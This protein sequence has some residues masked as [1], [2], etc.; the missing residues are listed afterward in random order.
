MAHPPSLDTPSSASPAEPAPAPTTIT[1]PTAHP[2]I[3]RTASKTG[4]SPLRFSTTPSN[5]HPQ[6]AAT[7]QPSKRSFDQASAASPPRS[8]PQL[9]PPDVDQT[10]PPY[11][12][13]SSMTS[14][15]ME[16][17][18][19]PPPEEITTARA[20]PAGGSSTQLTPPSR[21]GHPPNKLAGLPRPYI[22]KPIIPSPA[23]MQETAAAIPAPP[24]A[25]RPRTVGAKAAAATR[26]T[27]MERVIGTTTLPIA[28]VQKIMR[29]DKDLT[30]AAKEAVFLV[31]IATEGFMKR[32]AGAGHKHAS[33]EGRLTIQIK[34]LATAAK[35]NE[36]LTFIEDILPYTIRASAALPKALDKKRA[37]AENLPKEGAGTIADAFSK[38]P[39]AVK[40]GGAKGGKGKGK[41]VAAPAAEFLVAGAING[42]RDVLMDT[43]GDA[44]GSAPSTSGMTSSNNLLGMPAGGHRLLSGDEMDAS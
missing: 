20:G 39:K 19:S 25:K 11:V 18:P 41:A 10:P 38:V 42:D 30:N 9:P 12:R 33:Q 8:I 21:P 17:S 1:K 16:P 14:N 36:E 13:E 26:P 28:R 34:D 3:H 37:Q 5:D 43:S 24:P 2:I 4:P 32:L 31:T 23:Q 27:A 40:A 7:R 15:P 6:A 22:P 35:Q 29:A 44:V